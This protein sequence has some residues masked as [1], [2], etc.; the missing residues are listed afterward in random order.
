[1]HIIA[2][3]PQVT[4]AAAVHDQRLVSATENMTVKLMPVV[5]PDGIT[6]QQPAHPGHQIGPGRFH[7]QVKM[8]A[9]QT[10]SMHLPPSLLTGLSQRLQ[11]V[12]AVHIIQKDVFPPITPTQDMVD[13][14]CDLAKFK[15]PHFY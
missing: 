3:G 15:I 12:L 13:C 7:H 5:E 2:D 8:V 11:E 4:V 9:H 14:S 6:A 1:M 10:I